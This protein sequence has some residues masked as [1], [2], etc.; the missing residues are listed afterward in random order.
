MGSIIPVLVRQSLASYSHIL[1]SNQLT[2]ETEGGN[3]KSS[4]A[5]LENHNLPV[6]GLQVKGPGG[7]DEALGGAHNIVA[8]AGHGLHHGGRLG[9]E[10]HGSELCWG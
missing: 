3:L 1:E 8:P 4:Q 10:S 5:H 9:A 6:V 2:L 7:G